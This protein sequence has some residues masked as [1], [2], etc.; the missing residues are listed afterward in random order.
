MGF[1]LK[2]HLKLRRVA[3]SVGPSLPADGW[4]TGMGVG[5]PDVASRKRANW[6]SRGKC[7]SPTDDQNSKMFLQS[8]HKI[9]IPVF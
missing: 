2:T 7:T 3:M 5:A 1:P 6:A 9:Q 4:S 8:F